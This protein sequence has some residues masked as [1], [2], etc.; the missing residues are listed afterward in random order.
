MF[1]VDGG[2]VAAHWPPCLMSWQVLT[3]R[4]K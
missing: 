3:S 1:Y 2:L 4:T